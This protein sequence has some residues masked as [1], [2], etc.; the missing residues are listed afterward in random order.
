M[1]CVHFLPEEM[2]TAGAVG[3]YFLIL[4]LFGSLGCPVFGE[5]RVKKTHSSTFTTA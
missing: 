3:D 4:R 5:T 2:G 1:A